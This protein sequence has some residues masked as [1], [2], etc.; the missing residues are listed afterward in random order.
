M[1]KN[2]SHRLVLLD[3]HAILHRAYHALPEFA[4]SKGEPTGAIY[5]LISMLLKI[6]TDLKPDYIVACYDLPGPTYRH[7]AYE[8]YKAQRKKADD[9]LVHQMKRSRDVF[10]A[11]AIPMYDKPGFEA[12]D[13]LGTIVELTKDNKDLEIIIASGD[14]DTLQLVKGEKVRVYT[15]K[16][17]INDTI[18]YDEKGVYDRFHF[19]PKLLPDYKGLRGDPSDNI[20]GV[21]GIGEKTAETLIT[22][23]GTLESLYEEIKKD[24]EKIKKV[25]ITERILTLLEENEEEALFSKMLATIR[26]DA[27]IDF[28][29][30][31]K[32]WKETFDVQKALQ[33]ANDLDF[34]TLGARIQSIAG[35]D[36]PAQAEEKESLVDIPRS[37]WADLSIMV[38]LLDSNKTNP[39]LAEIFATTRVKTIVEARNIL[40][41]RINKEGLQYVYEE[42][43]KPLIPVVEE[44]E[45]VGIK[46]DRSKLKELS[47]D[48]HKKLDALQASIWR[49]AGREFN[50]NSP[51]QLGVVLFDELGLGVKNQKKTSTGMRSTKESELEKMKDTHPI[52]E[53]VLSFREL[54]KLLSTYIDSI[55][56][57]LDAEDRLHTSLRQAGTTTGRMSSINPNLQN[58]PIKTD[59]GRNIR[60]AFIPEEGFDMVSIDYSQIEL[61]IAA[62]LSGD[63]KLVQIFKNGEDVHSAVASEVFGVSKENVDREMRRKAKVIN[64]GILY[65]MGVSALKQ[66]LGGTRE[67]AQTFY[68]AYFERFPELAAYLEKVKVDAERLGYTE[69]LFGRK[70]HFEG[71]RSKIPFIKAA[72]LRM[73]IN[74]PIQGTAADVIKLAM[75]ELAHFIRE[76]G[77]GDDIRMVLQV[78]D[79]LLFEIKKGKAK[80]Y[81][82]KLKAVMEGVIDEEKSRGVP[83]TA[84]A[85]VGSSWG[86]MESL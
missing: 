58:I 75:K 40:T 4:S 9:A 68:N 74:A 73:A 42:I 23:F 30:P 69:T 45:T 10:T 41:Q 54:G 14:M 29:L 39:D 52:I 46:V 1:K 85:K 84:E 61:R 72:A 25:G 67:E 82:P 43:E 59:L 83:C 13:M 35:G 12:D 51:K 38:W 19:P 36:T 48:Y 65:G 20:I 70:R 5:G 22:H 3:A 11:F 8:G 79:E 6:I 15:L 37:K 26:T 71:I 17:G 24:R 47:R 32:H 31:Q 28:V 7:E 76:Q 55:P 77:L 33:I 81:T 44:M 80:E 66:N 57:F 21:K 56:D 86:E 63:K 18:L 64:F 78:H 34:R 27:P 50:I 2:H 49:H 53:E 62:I 60:N 16:K